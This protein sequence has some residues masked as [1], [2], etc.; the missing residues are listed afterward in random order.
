MI[1]RY[2]LSDESELRLLEPRYARELFA[3]VDGNRAHLGR[4]LPWVTY[5]QSVEDRR[6][7]LCCTTREFANHGNFI[8]GIWHRGVLAGAVG[9][10]AVNVHHRRTSVFYYLGEAFQ[11]KGLVTQ[12]CRAVIDHAF[13]VLNAHRI[14]LFAASGNTRSRAV[15]ERLGFRHEGTRREA[16]QI[17]GQ[18]VDLEEYAVLE[19][20]WPTRGAITFS[21]PLNEEIELRIP[22]LSD[23]EVLFAL[24]DAN[25]ERLRPWLPWV[26]ETTCV[27]HTRSFIQFALTKLA[28]NEE[29]HWSIWYRGALAGVIGVHTID[30]RHRWAEIGYWLDEGCEGKGVMTH[31]CRAVLAH[32]FDTLDLNRVV[33]R[34]DTRNTRS[35]T[36]AERL[37]FTLEGTQQQASQVD[38]C[39]VDSHYFGLLREEWAWQEHTS[40]LADSGSENG[41][42]IC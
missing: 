34:C 36:V 32:L 28:E 25:R 35:R 18:F 17:D 10:N 30:W 12:G 33:I 5:C 41:G 13:T 23:A 40:I 14:E 6:A 26:D 7:D 3:L 2:P 22:Q 11:G 21:C 24:V 15:A 27:E 31:A 20:D 42:V 16:Y 37:G 9:M 38:G 8:A 19:G 4:W 1:F 29:M 39:F